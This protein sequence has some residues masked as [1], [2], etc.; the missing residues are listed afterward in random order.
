V[1][2]DDTFF[3]PIFRLLLFSIK[4]FDRFT[5]KHFYLQANNIDIDIDDEITRVPFAS[6]NNCIS[7]VSPNMLNNKCFAGYNILTFAKMRKT[8]L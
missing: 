2:P 3:F 1:D 4:L 6:G 7:N 8:D 5:K